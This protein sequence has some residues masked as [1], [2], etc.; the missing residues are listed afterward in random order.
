[1]GIAQSLTLLLSYQA[2]LGLIPDVPQIF[3]HKDLLIL[4]WL[5]DSTLRI[6]SADTKKALIV[7]QAHLVLANGKIVQQKSWLILSVA[8]LII[9][10][11]KNLLPISFH[12][13]HALENDFVHLENRPKVSLTVLNGLNYF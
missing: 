2:G 4:L 6:E 3:L 13:G 11:F 10:H 9:S 8:F 5:I 7:N 12:R 1:M